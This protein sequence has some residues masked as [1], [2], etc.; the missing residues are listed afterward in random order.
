MGATIGGKR[1]TRLPSGR[2]DQAS[3]A[4]RNTPHTGQNPSLQSFGATKNS[5]KNTGTPQAQFADAT[6]QYLF[7]NAKIGKSPPSS[8]QSKNVGSAKLK[9][10]SKLQKEGSDAQT[11]D[12]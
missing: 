2:P 4:S 3:E 12:N 5:L 11:G 1:A 7:G 9:R 8:G 10:E 6:G